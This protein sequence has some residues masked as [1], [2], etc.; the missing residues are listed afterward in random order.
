M[1][2]ESFLKRHSISRPWL[3]SQKQQLTVMQ[4][5]S[6]NQNQKQVI[7]SVLR[8][9]FIWS[10]TES[11]SRYSSK[12]RKF[13]SFKI[14]IFRIRPMKFFLEK[15]Y[16]VRVAHEK[17]PYGVILAWSESFMRHPIK[18]CLNFSSFLSSDVS[19]YCFRFF[20]GPILVR[21]S[22]YVFSSR[23]KVKIWILK[24]RGLDWRRESLKPAYAISFLALRERIQNLKLAFQSSRNYYYYMKIYGLIILF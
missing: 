11:E 22:Q 20:F 15:F 23:K 2:F 12:F 3:R 9:L 10:H 19:D 14:C 18:S 1:V 5:E 13:F 7:R 8:R 4:F 21:R 6:Q 24:K 17:W 16:G